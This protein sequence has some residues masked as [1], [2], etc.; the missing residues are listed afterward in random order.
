[1]GVRL[2][3]PVAM[4][5]AATVVDS[6]SSM[7]KT[8]V[9][10]LAV[11]PGAQVRTDTIIDEL[12]GEALPR[13]PRSAVHAL[14]S[15]LR[16]WLREAG[17]AEHALRHANDGYHLAVEP[18]QVDLRRFVSVAQSILHGS[19]M[20]PAATL[21]G[22]DRARV[23][24]KGDPFGGCVSTPR[25]DG[26]RVRVSELA[27]ALARRRCT[28]LV[29]L[30]RYEPA[31]ADLRAMLAEN[32][33][34][35]ELAA[36]AMKALYRA[37]RQREA[38]QLYQET[39]Q[40]LAE[41]YGMEPSLQLTDLEGRILR[42][43]PALSG[44]PVLSDGPLAPQAARPFVVGR[45]E[46]LANITRYRAQTRGG[47]LV[48]SGEA[49]AGKTT[50]LQAA[51]WEARRDGAIVGLG[52]F[53]RGG[54]PLAAWRDALRQVNIDPAT[55]TPGRDGVPVGRRVH[56]ALLRATSSA[57]IVLVLEDVH[58]ADS[59]SLGL[60]LMLA[61]AGLGPNVGLLITVREPAV[62]PHEDWRATLA[63][64]ARLPEVR[65]LRVGGLSED[66]VREVV[67]DRLEQLTADSANRLGDLLHERCGGHALH[68]SALLDVMA[69][70]PDETACELAS[71]RVPDRLLPL[72]RYN[73]ESLAQPTREAL[74]ALGILGPSP[75]SALADVLGT[76]VMSVL[77][78]L[79]PAVQLGLV[80]EEDGTFRHRHALTEQVVVEDTP[81]STRALLHLGALERLQRPQADPF[82]LLRHAQAGGPLV[83]P[84]RLGAIQLAAA[85]SAYSR[86]AFGEACT[87]AADARVN[88]K[89]EAR[90]EADLYRGLSL[91]ALG[92]TSD[93]DG[94]LEGVIQ[95]SDPG[96][97]LAVQAAVGHEPLGLSASG[98]TRRV[99]RLQR[100]LS[101]SPPGATTHRLDLLRALVAEEALLYGELRTVGAQEELAKMAAQLDSDGDRARLAHFNARGLVDAPVR[102]LV[103]L[104]AAELALDHA[105]RSKDLLLRLNAL[106]LMVSATLAAAQLERCQDLLWELSRTAER[107]GRPRSRW[108]AS[109]VE[110]ALLVA[111]GSSE[112]EAAAEAALALGT[113]LGIADA[114]GA[115][116][117]HR[118]GVQLLEGD[119][120]PIL[121]LAQMAVTMYPNVPAWHAAASLAHAHAGDTNESGDHLA[122]FL[123]LR[124]PAATRHFDR[125]GLG[126]AA[127]AAA[128]LGD[129]TAAAEVLESLSAD[130]AM[131]VVG[132]GAA[133][134]GPVSLCVARA[135]AALGRH[136]VAAVH[137]DEAISLVQELGWHPW[138]AVCTRWSDALEGSGPASE[139]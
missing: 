109:L 37:G 7:L 99:S 136:D 76:T 121:P 79:R 92:R 85:R 69:S 133:V 28:A 21:E 132:A 120:S 36:A 34:R 30:G 87:L 47:L 70:L 51:A 64:L 106:E 83:D 107:A 25:L 10:L 104:Q 102:A 108:V 18:D 38:L 86:G 88:L 66:A 6:K 117:V 65:Q 90:L 77:R 110:A 111:S 123:K 60:L 81:A 26:E 139:G 15:R 135:E 31:I 16:R 2:L 103:R 55:L 41:L 100:V 4:V 13:D 45:T 35:E 112:G 53:A 78:T 124:R 61:T 93:A 17:G 59:T 122:R 118:L 74:E 71:R 23:E 42:Q 48:V 113:S 89:P 129:G 57:P 40:L 8:L 49:G 24:W 19:E 72:I 39:R 134:F 97:E 119:L 44:P 22:C 138:E 46:E 98:D 91:A 5:R 54:A 29:A 12:W 128:E 126:L 1:M 62:E 33:S 3:G 73:I 131:I 96:S 43:D 125:P 20:D 56:E 27:L 82:A 32:P 115:Y 95:G 67:A 116:G 75:A 114:V 101:A 94:V 84:P 11:S 58:Q 50:L 63:D 9:A 137:M 105:T 130:R 127:H 68:L 52:S 14:V 80:I